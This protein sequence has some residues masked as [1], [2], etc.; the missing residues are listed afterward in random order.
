[1]RGG[2]IVHH[3]QRQNQLHTI[4][5]HLEIRTDR[6]PDVPLLRGS[7]KHI[8]EQKEKNNQLVELIGIVKNEKLRL[9]DHLALLE[10]RIG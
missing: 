5:P 7:K 10:D 4:H 2:H 8:S 9:Q 3:P 6:L 1:M